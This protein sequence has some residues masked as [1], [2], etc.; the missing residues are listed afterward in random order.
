MLIHFQSLCR[1]RDVKHSSIKFH[2]DISKISKTVQRDLTIIL[3]V[4]LEYVIDFVLNLVFLEVAFIGFIIVFLLDLSG[5]QPLVPCPHVLLTFM[6]FLQLKV[7]CLICEAYQNLLKHL[8]V[9][10]NWL[11]WFRFLILLA[12]PL[13]ILIGCMIFVSPFLVVITISM[14]TVLFLAQL[15]LGILYPQCAFL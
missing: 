5:P 9:N 3:D 1:Q 14:S 15:E 7:R 2:A 10:L 8:D 4:L 6:S 12:V 13:V 11:N